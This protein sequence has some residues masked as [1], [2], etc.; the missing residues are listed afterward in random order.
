MR[1]PGSTYRLQINNTFT[2]SDA[3]KIINY[4]EKLGVTDLYFSPILQAVKNSMHGYDVI[5]HNSINSEIGSFE[6]IESLAHLLKER[7]MGILVDIVPN[8]MAFNGENRYIIDI[9]ENDKFSK[10]YNYFDINWNHTFESINGKLITP[11]LGKFYGECLDNGELSIKYDHFGFYVSYYEN[12]FCMKIDSYYDILIYKQYRLKKQLG[13]DSPDYIKYLG[14]LYII[15]NLS[16]EEDDFKDRYDQVRFIKAVMWE[17]YNKCEAFK[18]FIDENIQEINGIKGNSETFNTLDEILSKQVFRLTYWK[19]ATDEI[20]YRR[21]FNVNGLISLR[22]EDD[23]VFNKVHSYI[24]ELMIAGI[25]DG[26]RI[27]HIDGLSDPAGYLQRLKSRTNDAYIVV[28]KI[29]ETDEELPSDWNC[30]GTVGYDYLNYLNGLFIR[31]SNSRPFLKI[32]HDFTAE[33]WNYKELLYEKKRMMLTRHMSGDMDNLARLIKKVASN[34]RYASDY[35]FTGLKMA[36]E[37]LIVLFPVYRTYVNEGNIISPQDR[38][39]I[40]KTVQLARKFNPSLVYELNFIESILLLKY[41]NKGKEHLR[42]DIIEFVMK[43]QQ[44]TGPLMAKG[45]ED[46]LFYSYNNFISL[47]EVGGDPGRFGITALEFHKFNIQRSR[48]LPCSMNASSTHDTKR[49]EDLRARL[50]VLSEIPLIWGRNIKKWHR[51][52]KKYKKIV[53]KVEFPDKND[54]YFIYQIL[55]GSLPFDFNE[56]D[57]YK[58]RVK[59]YIIKAVRE[60]KTHTNWLKPEQIYEDAILDFIDKILTESD[61]NN[62]L[63]DFRLFHRNIAFNG[64]LNSI[65][66]VMLKV[67]S[68]GIPDIYQ[69]TELW[70]FSFVDPDNRRPVDFKL[71]ERFLEEIISTAERNDKH[72]LRELFINY[73]DARIKLY[74]TYI[75]L[76]VRNKNKLLF[77]EGDYIPLVI[78][79]KY[80]EN[81]AAFIRTGKN[82]ETVVIVII[83]RFHTTFVNTDRD[84][85]QMLSILE[86]KSSTLLKDTFIEIPAFAQRTYTNYITGEKLEIG[87]V[88]KIPDVMG[89]TV[90]SLL[91]SE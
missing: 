27:D 3:E 72:S 86:E 82:R 54:E 42:D 29:L 87:S 88:V 2:L 75:S 62:F 58:N 40:I 53:K 1:I 22:I 78:K 14:L 12:R 73:N 70:D 48:K 44:Y 68:P 66:Q 8:H 17:L 50:N 64:M 5:D 46:T 7:N 20:N 28:E 61:D 84:S 11:F 47:N 18:I 30:E 37:E 21:F 35:T 31:K 13:K 57:S 52:N 23:N 89:I 36:L 16:S 33:E 6:E 77:T 85:D 24:F 76:K 74:F 19:V 60:S 4:I 65:S 59:E 9:F 26:L 45:L 43:F 41:S 55:S 39:V 51:L 79:G 63:K 10:Y 15:K 67:L 80:K 69:G 49:G 32:Y 56:M 71:R 90:H 91:V 25:I 81:A 34:D 38:K 83:S